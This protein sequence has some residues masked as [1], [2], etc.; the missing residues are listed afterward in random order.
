VLLNEPGR[1]VTGGEFALVESAP[2]AQS[3]A[4]VVSLAQGDMVLFAVN[5]RP[6]PSV[7]GVKRVTLRHGVSRVRS[8]H[9]MTLGVIFHDAA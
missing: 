8:G 6:V 5:A 9:R 4:E 1:D 2:R 3:R 7:R